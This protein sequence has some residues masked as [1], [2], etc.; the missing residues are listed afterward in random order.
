MR[1]YIRKMREKAEKH[2]KLLAEQA[3]GKAERQAQALAKT[4]TESMT[5][6]EGVQSQADAAPE[7]AE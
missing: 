2:Q 4:L 6:A 7:T 3:R 5:G 1:N